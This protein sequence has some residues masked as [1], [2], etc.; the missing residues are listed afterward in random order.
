MW[1]FE[2]E[3]TLKSSLHFRILSLQ[4][5]YNM[6]YTLDRTI[7]YRVTQ[8]VFALLYLLLSIDNFTNDKPKK[9]TK[10]NVLE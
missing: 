2:N 1:C 5:V 10:E 4:T 8:R 9:K 6:R 7:S 3:H